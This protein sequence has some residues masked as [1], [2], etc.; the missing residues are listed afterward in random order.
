LHLLKLQRYRLVGNKISLN[1][2]L[3]KGDDKYIDAEV[4]KKL[5]KK[6]G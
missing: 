4:L 5:L 2:K 3:K 6:G 1:F